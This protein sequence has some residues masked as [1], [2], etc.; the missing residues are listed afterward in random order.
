[1]RIV[2]KTQQRRLA[3]GA[4]RGAAAAKWLLAH[5]EIDEQSCRDSIVRLAYQTN[6]GKRTSAIFLDGHFRGVGICSNGGRKQT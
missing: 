3:R 5:A 2:F 1:M 4:A 6:D